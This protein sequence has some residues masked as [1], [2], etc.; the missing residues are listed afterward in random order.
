MALRPKI[1]AGLASI[2]RDDW[3][4]R[5]VVI[6]V[7][8]AWVPTL[9]VYVASWISGTGFATNVNTH[10]GAFFASWVS[11]VA[12][13]SFAAIGTIVSLAQPHL[14][15]FDGRARIL[16]RRQTGNHIDYIIS[17]IT[18]ALEHYA[19]KTVIRISILDYDATERKF[20]VSSASDITVRSYLDDVPTTYNSEFVLR[21][22]ALPPPGGQPNRLIYLRVNGDPV[23]ASEPFGSHILRPLQCEI[24]KDS[25]CT[26]S[27]AAEYWILADD[28]SNIH[29]PKR[30]TQHLQLH[31]ENLTSAK[32]DVTL[33]II[34]RGN[35][36]ETLQL[37]PGKVRKALEILDIKP[38]EQAYDFRILKP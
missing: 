6:A 29:K 25:A 22:I 7:G 14:E 36:S 21:D 4:V 11:G 28:E 19:E 17:K 10:F 38:G 8:I 2:R 9:L 3:R 13:F 33:K 16:F 5:A 37:G 35:R 27:R 23:G 1:E 18:Q 15:P 20:R 24:A 34:T 26:V 31:F 30:Y 32:Q 12:L